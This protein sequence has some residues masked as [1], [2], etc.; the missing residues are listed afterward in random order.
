MVFAHPG[1]DERHHRQPKQQ[2]QI[3]PQHRAIDP[4]DDLPEVVVVVPVDADKH[5]TQQVAEKLRPQRPECRY[6][7]LVRHPE[8]QDHDGDDDGEHAIAERFEP[9]LVHAWDSPDSLTGVAP[10]AW[11]PA[12]AIARAIVP[13]ARR[14]RWRTAPADSPTSAGSNP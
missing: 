13:T 14:P 6:G 12:P 11:R 3:G 1:G 8:F 9:R 5:K 10:A 2:M 4:L 7:R